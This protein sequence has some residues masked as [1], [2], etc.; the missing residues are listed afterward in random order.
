M[1]NIILMLLC[2]SMACAQGD[3][4]IEAGTGYMLG[5]ER[6]IKGPMTRL[7]AGIFDRSSSD[8]LEIKWQIGLLGYTGGIKQYSGAGGYAGFGYVLGKGRGTL[9]EIDISGVY[10][11]GYYKG[12]GILDINVVFTRS[13][14]S[15]F[16]IRGTFVSMNNDNEENDEGNTNVFG[17]SFVIR[18][19]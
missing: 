15:E 7:A 4:Y 5:G 9:L 12:G 3:S 10:S 16:L 19:F 8:H 11:G 18:K 13:K 2:A 1:R 14:N 17:L 6:D